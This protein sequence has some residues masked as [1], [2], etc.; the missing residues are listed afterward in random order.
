MSK[1]RLLRKRKMLPKTK[2]VAA[3]VLIVS[4]LIGLMIYRYTAIR[5]QGSFTDRQGQQMID[6]RGNKL[7]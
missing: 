3:L 5:M 1:S 7:E 6:Q 4:I 2:F